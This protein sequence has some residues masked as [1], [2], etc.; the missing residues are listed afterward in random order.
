[1]ELSWFHQARQFKSP[2]RILAAVFLRSREAQAAKRR[3]WQ[4]RCVQQERELDQ[5]AKQ[6]EEQQRELLRLK[7]RIRVLERER[8]EALQ[9]PPVWPADPPVGSHGYGPQMVCLAVNLAQKVGMRGAE[10]ALKIFLSLW[11]SRSRSRTTPPF[12]TG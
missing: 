10:S 11:G 8:D 5:Q 9:Q 3:H 2:A 1:M 12:A 7:E 6:I 4:E